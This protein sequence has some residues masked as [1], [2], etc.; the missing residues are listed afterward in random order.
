MF[1]VTQKPLATRPWHVV[2]VLVTTQ[3]GL[4][5]LQKYFFFSS[6]VIVKEDWYYYPVILL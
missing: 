5:V 3:I 4:I 2:L 6:F 1:L